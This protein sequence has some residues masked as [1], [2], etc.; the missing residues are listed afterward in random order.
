MVP[1][2]IVAMSLQSAPP[3]VVSI[4]PPTGMPGD[5]VIINGQGFAGCPDNLCLVIMP[6]GS[7]QVVPLD[8]LGATDTQIRARI[9]NVPP[10]LAGVPGQVMVARG[11]GNRVKPVPAFPD[12]IIEEPI[13]VWE[14]A[15]G[16]V[17]NDK[18]NDP[19]QP[20]PVPIPTFT[21]HACPRRCPTPCGS[22]AA[23]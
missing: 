20:D 5:I 23:W 12:V 6:A 21:P 18:Q 13:W 3:V 10:Q 1:I 15:D 17:E 19:T 11:N 2:E 22:L 7:D 14:R 9:L 4:D 8:V 16:N